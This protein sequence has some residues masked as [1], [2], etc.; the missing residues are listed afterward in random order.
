M[1]FT[2]A[3]MRTEIWE[4][5]GKPTNLDPETTVGLNRLNLVI[6]EAQRQV[7]K[8]KDPQTGRR[9]MLNCL[10]ASTNFF[11]RSLTG[12]I[13]NIGTNL[14][15]LETDLLQTGDS[16]GRYNNWIVEDVTTGEKRIIVDH[17]VTGSTNSFWTDNAFTTAPLIGNNLLIYKGFFPILQPAHAWYTDGIGFSPALTN[18]LGP[19]NLLEILAVSDLERQKKLGVGESKNHFIDRYTNT[20]DPG[21]WERFG[22]VIELD[23]NIREERWFRLEYYRMPTTL[24]DNTDTPEIPETLHWAMI[25]WGMSWGY[26]LRQENSSFYSTMRNFDDEMRKSVT[27]FMVGNDRTSSQY[28]PEMK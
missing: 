11:A 17:I 18:H 8:W 5:V 14:A 22:N 7:A 13:N 6:N 1:S 2:L 10:Y 23:I 15:Y 9:M 3:Q 28:Y 19:D 4:A 26:R 27:D 20:G 16:S 21:K 24:T 25:L 12:T